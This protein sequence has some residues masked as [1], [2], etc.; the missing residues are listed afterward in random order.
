MRRYVKNTLTMFAGLMSIGIALVVGIPIYLED[1]ESGF[2]LPS[3]GVLGMAADVAPVD[4]A[5]ASFGD[6]STWVASRADVATGL[7]ESR[8]PWLELSNKGTWT[9]RV[10]GE[11]TEG[12]GGSVIVVY[13]WDPEASR[14]SYYPEP[15]TVKGSWVI[16]A[17][18]VEEL[19]YWLIRDS[20]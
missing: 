10:D 17:P 14:F 2:L 19:D 1:C 15:G 11:D 6:S 4:S 16:R 18:T 12:V 20:K 5:S 7:S 13:E 3:D 9:H 8:G